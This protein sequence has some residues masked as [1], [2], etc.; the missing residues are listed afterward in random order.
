M[1]NQN[2][3]K[4]PK[5]SDAKGNQ[6]RTMIYPMAGFYLIYQAYCMYQEL[7]VTSGNQHT[8]M[9]ASAIFFVIAGVGLIIFGTYIGF[10]NSKKKKYDLEEQKEQE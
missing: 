3:N 6:V 4:K 2:E 10:K 8:L 5:V 9:V 1:D 7:S